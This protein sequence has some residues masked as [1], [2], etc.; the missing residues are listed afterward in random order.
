MVS[1]A[2]LLGAVLLP[3]VWL[4]QAHRGYAVAGID[5]VDERLVGLYAAGSMVLAWYAF[6]I[7][8]LPFLLLHLTMA[9]FTAT[10]FG[11]LVWVKRVRRD[12]DEA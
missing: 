4:A 1:V 9:M 8:D 2:A 11:L 10:E 7:G 5:A 12:D 6:S 3:A